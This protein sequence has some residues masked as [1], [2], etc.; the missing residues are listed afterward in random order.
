M[1]ATRI[2]KDSM[3]EMQVPADALWGA[4]TQR[5]VLNFPVSGLRFGRK[6]VRAMG[7]VKYACAMAN[8]SLGRLDPKIAA[9]IKQAAREVADGKWD[10]HFVVDIF[11]TGSGTSTNMNAN[12]VI[13]NRAAQI[14]GGKAG[15][16]AIHPNDHVNMGQSS[17]DIIPTVAHV[18]VTEALH[19]EFMPHLHRLHNALKQK[20]EEFRDVIKIG[21]THLMD[22][23]PITLGQEFSGY[24]SQIS[25][26]D[27]RV[28]GAVI[29]LREL[30]IGG[31]AVGT[32]IN[33]HP[34]FAKRVCEILNHETQ[35]AFQEAP[36]HFEAQ[37]AN[38][39]MVEI[40]A[41][42]K[43]VAV[44]LAKIA[45]DIRMLGSGP[46]CG[47]G[48]IMLPEI[49]PGSSIMPGKVNPVVCEAV[50]QV[51]AQVIGCDATVT[52]AASMMSNFELHAAHPVIAR[53][54]L[55]SIRLLG[56]VCDVFVD[57]CISGIKANE[58]RCADLVEHS[59][60]MCTSLAP[61]IGYDAAAAIAKE[62]YQTGKTVREIAGTKGSL[63]AA[64]LNELLDPRSMTKP[65]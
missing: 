57:K 13:A 49:Q 37:A 14:A 47:V 28:M 11:Q 25:H 35:E 58:K 30:P 3:G 20:A 45:N 56:N 33:T 39:A 55:E 65:S 27:R 51:C 1:A 52:W 44:S 34:Q 10:D 38:D 43:T 24:A 16:K 40:A 12:E 60:A 64:K 42:L 32:G 15:D 6:F 8:E 9:S 53:N 5:A 17:N 36:N 29:K 7:L 19:H 59:L 54:I 62:A 4:S 22:A 63:S 48:E 26:A 23:T 41:E 50:L 2:E 61:H 46:R 31:T 18:A 21:R